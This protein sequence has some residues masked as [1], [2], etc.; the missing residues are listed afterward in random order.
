MQFLWLFKW[1]QRFTSLI[2]V[3]KIPRVLFN[4]GFFIL[5]SSPIAT[6]NT[7]CIAIIISIGNNIYSCRHTI[8]KIHCVIWIIWTT[9]ALTWITTVIITIVFAIIISIIVHK[10]RKKDDEEDIEETK[11]PK[12]SKKAKHEK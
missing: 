6:W 3:T 5:S 7:T 8:C 12:K 1:F 4:W 11:R 9:I 2:V 10:C